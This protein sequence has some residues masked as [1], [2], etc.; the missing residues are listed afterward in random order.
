MKNQRRKTKGRWPEVQRA[1]SRYTVTLTEENVERA[2]KREENLSRPTRR[3]LARWLG[4]I[5]RSLASR[6]WR[7]SSSDSNKL[8]AVDGLR[9]GNLLDLLQASW[10]ASRSA[11]MVSIL[12]LDCHNATN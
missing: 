4:S 10:L 2:K 8:L 11:M 5:S 9:V 3:L 12:T 7:L 6:N 1:K